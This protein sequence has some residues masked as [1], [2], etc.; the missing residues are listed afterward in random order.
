MAGFR[1]R[2]LRVQ[3]F[4]VGPDF[5]DPGFH[6]AA[7]GRPSH[8][9]DGWML[10]R[11]VNSEIFLRASKNA[12]I[13]IVE[14]VMGLFDGRSGTDD[15]GS[16]AEIAKWLNASVVLVV[17]ASAMARSGAALVHGFES[18]DS[19][20]DVAGVIFNRVAGDGHFAYLRDAVT[21]SCRSMP[22]GYVPVESAVKLSERHLGLRLAEEV[23]PAGYFDTLSD[24]IQRTVDLDR[25][26]KLASKGA[27][28]VSTPLA[29][30][31]TC[32]KRS[33]V[34]ARIGIARDQAFAFY[35]EE[36]L[37]HLEDSG[38]ELVEFSS[39]HGEQLPDGLDGL[40]IG[41][42]YP[43]LHAKRLADNRAMIAGIRQ[44]AAGG[45][46]VY[47]ECGGFMYLSDAIV[48]VDGRSFEM[49]GIFPVRARM[50]TR[51]AALGYVEIVQRETI[52][53]LQGG[54]RMRGHQF[55]Y[56]TI[57]DMPQAIRRVYGAEGKCDGEAVGYM[58]GSVLGSYIHLHFGSCP[59]FARRFVAACQAHGDNVR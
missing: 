52:A 29:I 49:V 58:A 37:R 55:R 42:G 12:D 45:A 20:L 16:T 15:A 22:L 47:A 51:L 27:K 11:E 14:G 32:C 24:W 39:L 13:V 40:Y 38:A 4:K 33:S 3:A 8:N 43:E 50:Q 30:G 9:L 7:T 23:I 34:R 28:F 21:A 48:D 19:D 44:L 6:R 2:G 41:G 35:Y 18:F 46:P 5:I 54:E 31:S 10:S 1:R 59:D 36:N 53:W 57:D 25:I 26:Y 56:S 17:D